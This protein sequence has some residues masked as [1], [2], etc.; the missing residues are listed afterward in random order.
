MPRNKH[1][2]TNQLE[3]FLCDTPADKW[4]SWHERVIRSRLL[5]YFLRPN[6]EKGRHRIMA[7]TSI[8]LQKQL[9]QTIK[10]GENTRLLRTLLENEEAVSKEQNWPSILTKSSSEKAYRHQLYF[11]KARGTRYLVRLLTAGH[12][13]ITFALEGH[14]WDIDKK[15][16]RTRISPHA[17]HGHTTSLK[18]PWLLDS[19]QNSRTENFS[20]YVGIAHLAAAFYLILMPRKDFTFG[21]T[22]F[23]MWRKNLARFFGL[24]YAF[25]EFLPKQRQRSVK[26]PP[27]A[28]KLLLLP[29]IAGIEVSN[30]PIDAMREAFQLPDT[31]RPQ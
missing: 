13:A 1:T 2:A 29:E 23:T 14:D 4:T 5:A 6:D 11:P 15:K 18:Y 30:L 25:Q 12:V 28:N 24:A 20:Q 22:E 26:K 17:A 9:A 16:V 31:D 8:S 21:R 7:V 10:D 27:F 19:H 3:L